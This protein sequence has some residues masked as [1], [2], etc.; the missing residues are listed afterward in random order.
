MRHE[1]V[2]PSG[3][4]QL[5]AA[6]R[7][8]CDAYLYLLGR[9]LVL[10]QEHLDILSGTEWN[11]LLHHEPGA[12]LTSSEA[13][14]VVDENS[15][16]VIDVPEISGRYYTVHVLNPWGE[17]IANI[18]ERTF[19]DRPVGSFALCLKGSSTAL[20]DGAR[21]IDLPGRK[22][23][24][25]IHV[26]L[27]AN[28]ADAMA[29][30]RA[31]AMHATGSPIV[32]ATIGI[33]LFPNDELP[34]VEA[35]DAALAVLATERDINRGVEAIQAKVH[36]MAELVRAD[37][38]GRIDRVIRQRSWG[39]RQA[40]YASQNEWLTAR[41]VG[42]YG[43]DWLART[44]ANMFELWA[45]T[46]SEVIRFQAGAATPLDGDETY[47]M[48]FD[49]DHP[50]PHV[51]HFWSICVNGV[52]S[53]RPLLSSHSELHVGRNGTLSLYFAPTLPHGAPEQN[54][55]P[56]PAAQRYS[57]DWRSYGPDDMGRWFPPSLQQISTLATS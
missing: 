33:P 51:H 55:L 47:V 20:P 5:G 6:D 12:Q 26:E 13:W 24:V 17:T 48:K 10:R 32:T 25:L 28:P 21:R 45:N 31:F 29:L 56:T 50:T 35:F 1:N 36:A 2:A 7:D 9:L 39:L 37:E 54:W 19:P 23:R 11:Q 40:L 30:Q 53:N 22:A 41:V 18:N 27:G 3:R 38:R 34:G 57:L 52:T 4:A 42:N 14:V 8:I 46:K 15:S 43:A 16:T 44:A 49:R